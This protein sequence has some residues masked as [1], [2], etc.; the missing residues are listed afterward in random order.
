MTNDAQNALRRG[1]CCLTTTILPI[2][3]DVGNLC[4]F[5]NLIVLNK[6]VFFNPA[7]GI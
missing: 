7:L 6:S 4:Y 2:A 1:V 3:L 5:S